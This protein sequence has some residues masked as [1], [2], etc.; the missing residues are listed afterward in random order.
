MIKVNH[1]NFVLKDETGYDYILLWSN[2][3]RVLGCISFN[4]FEYMVIKFDIKF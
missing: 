2:I 3:T 1:I 4:S